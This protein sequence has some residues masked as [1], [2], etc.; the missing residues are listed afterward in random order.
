[1][2]KKINKKLSN[3]LF[4]VLLVILINTCQTPKEPDTEPPVIE[5]IYPLNNQTI[6]EEIKIIAEASD[7]DAL[8]QILFSINGEIGQNR[9]INSPPWELNLKTFEYP[10][11]SNIEIIAIARDESG[12]ETIS[13]LVTTTIDNSSHYPEN[14]NII[15]VEYD[16]ENM[17][18]NWSKSNDSDFS[19]YNLYYAQNNN[20]FNVAELLY[21]SYNLNDTSYTIELNPNL[22]YPTIENWFWVEST[23]SAGLSTLSQS[24]SNSTE[25]PPSPINNITVFYQTEFTNGE[26]IKTLN[27]AWLQSADWDFKSYKIE[28]QSGFDS[29]D[30]NWDHL[31]TI[32]DINQNIYQTT[33]FEPSTDFTDIAHWFKITVE[34]IWGQTTS[35]P[36]FNDF[37]I[38][39]P[40]PPSDIIS[41]NYDINAMTV[42][43]EQIQEDPIEFNYYNIYHSTTNN[44]SNAEIIHN[45]IMSCN[46]L[47]NENDCESDNNCSW[48]NEEICYNNS[49]YDTTWSYEYSISDT[50]YF[51]GNENWF[52][53]GI[54]D[55][56]EAESVGNALSN[57]IK[58]LPNPINITSIS[59]DETTTLK[60]I[61][62]S[63][64]ANNESDFSNYKLYKSE[65][66][67]SYDTKQLIN[68]IEQQY[69]N[70]FT[71]CITYD[72][73]SNDN[74]IYIN[75]EYE[76]WF[77]IT[78]SNHWDQ[79]SNQ[80]EGMIIPEIPLPDAVNVISV[81]YNIS[82]MIVTWNQSNDNDFA[83]YVLYKS[84][85][86]NGVYDSIY[87]IT[88]RLQT[89][90][91]FSNFDPTIENWYKIKTTDEQLQSAYGSPK[92]NNI[93][94]PPSAVTLDPITFNSLNSELELNWDINE[95]TDFINY[96]IYESSN[97]DMT[98]ANSISTINNRQT[99]SLNRQV[100]PDM[101]SNN[102]IL[103]YQVLVEDIWGQKSYSN[104]ESGSNHEK[105]IFSR[106]SSN[107][108]FIFSVHSDENNG[109]YTTSGIK[110][111]KIWL[112]QITF[113]GIFEKE[114]TYEFGLSGVGESDK[115]MLYFDN[116]Y[117]LTGWTQDIDNDLDAYI[118]E[119]DQNLISLN[120]ANYHCA[121]FNCNDSNGNNICDSNENFIDS[122]ENDEDDDRSV[123][124]IN[125]S[126]DN[127]VIVGSTNDDELNK[128]FI[129][130]VKTN[131]EG[132]EIWN[133][134]R[135]L[136]YSSTFDNSASSIVE[137]NDGNYMVLANIDNGN[138]NTDIWIN[139]LDYTNGS[140]I[141][142]N[143]SELSNCNDTA[144]ICY[145]G[146]SIDE[147]YTILPFNGN[148]VIAGT[149][150]SK[151]NGGYDGWIIIVDENGSYI[152]DF[153][154][155]GIYDDKIYSITESANGYLTFCGYTRSF[156]SQNEDIWIFQ[157]DLNGDLI[158]N[159]TI[160][161][162]YADKGYGI[163]S[164]SDG[165]FIISGISQS[166]PGNYGNLEAVLIKTD[167]FGNTIDLD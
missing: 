70:S 93:D 144:G 34:D 150:R 80:G 84:D 1:M 39:G 35:S 139:K 17:I 49:I 163:K 75:P 54:V 108:D 155:G 114:E 73:N 92:S 123:A 6:F 18:I 101:I 143:E 50:N 16:L 149:T 27:I 79:E 133:T 147:A 128:F 19:H 135:S 62:V 162:Y 56:I 152:N 132:Q 82:N 83:S 12:N 74:C 43:W 121:T 67:W 44:F 47:E 157:I 24:K 102:E 13:D 105:F 86:F 142:N 46:N 117:F 30:D 119:F 98:N 94:E 59:L 4:F 25:T 138:Y 87:N 146:E 116:S 40:S 11:S 160:G 15:A 159:K 131:Y 31:K 91:S 53:I 97:Y 8:D 42:T 33:Q 51:P 99:L 122:Y 58:E 130:A 5:I 7:N 38:D 112:F 158:F 167:P 124:V 109:L 151:G 141:I 21:T 14:V 36:K 110:D 95:D 64:E 28:Y 165:G 106:G 68:T 89:S 103:F 29:N 66:E 129:W 45:T 100:D 113:D 9:I 69:D 140:I 48:S 161:G 76:N 3:L 10:D 72:S 111:N 118:M 120:D 60:E 126:D 78:T 156:N 137:T 57:E 71:N 90:L 164:T 96:I 145:G 65:F 22:I 136:P 32:T 107:Y 81:D 153:T 85:S 115:N 104:I 2:I 55:N 26:T 77:W 23:D 166:I 154:Y 125:S 20:N 148:Y 63:W 61:T 134:E 127:F 37:D 41:I 88:N 52:W